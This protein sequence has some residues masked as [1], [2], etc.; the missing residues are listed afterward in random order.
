MTATQILNNQ[1]NTYVSYI[2]CC[3]QAQLIEFAQ[4]MAN[5]L[6]GVAGAGALA[7][8]NGGAGAALTGYTTR[9]DGVTPVPNTGTVS[10][11]QSGIGGYFYSYQWSVDLGSFTDW[12]YSITG[13]ESV[14]SGDTPLIQ[15]KK[16]YATY[17]LRAVV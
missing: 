6:A 8:A 4:V 7:A 16:L 1:I 3:S 2:K 17:V 9:A 10:S 15:L 14:T 11:N 5:A 12:A 13:N